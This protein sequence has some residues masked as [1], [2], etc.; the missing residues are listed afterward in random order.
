MKMRK[1][2]S[3][4][5][6][7]GFSIIEALVAI[8]ILTVSIAGPMTI[9]QRGISTANLAKDQITAFFLAQ[10]VI[11]SIR[12]QRETNILSDLTWMNGL[13]QCI[14]SY[15]SF[16]NVGSP[17]FNTCIGEGLCEDLKYDR[18]SGFYGY[19]AG[20]EDTVFNR[21]FIMTQLSN[22]EIS[23]NVKVSWVSG[24]I[25]RNINVHETMFNWQ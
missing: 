6:S 18:S 16:D 13:T 15:C 17:S 7:S 3:K 9:A 25:N 1:V 24:K 23:I 11:E 14:G 12:A 4:T 19:E 10:E 22:N 5:Y 8:S 2:N 21:E 20:W